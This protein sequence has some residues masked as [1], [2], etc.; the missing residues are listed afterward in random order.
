M[1]LAIPHS[2]RLYFCPTILLGLI[3]FIA[4]STNVSAQPGKKSHGHSKKAKGNPSQAYFNHDHSHKHSNHGHNK[5]HENSQLIVVPFAYN[6]PNFAPGF[7]GG[8]W[9]GFSPEFIYGRGSM[10]SEFD[11]PRVWDYGSVYGPSYY[12]QSAYPSHHSLR[13]P[14]ESF[15]PA[16][17]EPLA[18]P[19]IHTKAIARSAQ[20]RAEAA[21]RNGDYQLA[22]GLARQVV[23]LDSDNGFAFL[24]ASH[25]SFAVCDYDQ[26]AKDLQIA[27]ELL[28][29]DQWDFVVK[30]YRHFYGRN[31]YVRQMEM[32]NNFLINRPLHVP[33][34]IVRGHH[35]GSLGHLKSAYDD[36][37]IAISKRANDETILKLL[38]RFNPAG[39]INPHANF[40][41]QP[42]PWLNEPPSLK[43]SVDQQAES[44]NDGL[45]EAPSFPPDQPPM[46]TLPAP[47]NHDK[48]ETL[49][50]FQLPNR[51]K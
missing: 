35:W 13:P 2:H 31:D 27:I 32:L 6:Q 16:P 39:V 29:A 42:A 36:L 44:T 25:T 37:S 38:E 47:D 28:P 11:S 21:F 4:S 17:N 15:T 10:F 23:T 1:I 30:N 43:N 22:S 49:D 51:Q 41:Q 18:Y 40:V 14:I 26:A 50:D 5:P 3:I 46:E 8:D 33:A 45:F 34:R 12:D 24:F 19:T 9:L 48:L 20:G 7:P